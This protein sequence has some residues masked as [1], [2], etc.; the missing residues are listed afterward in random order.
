[1]GGLGYLFSTVEDSGTEGYYQLK[2]KNGIVFYH[3]VMSR[4]LG[5]N[6]I[7]FF[8]SFLSKFG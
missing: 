6:I 8:L 1:M 2:W 7:I 4:I 3:S 5:M